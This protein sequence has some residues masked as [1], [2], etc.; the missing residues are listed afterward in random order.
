MPA[1]NDTVE[2]VLARLASGRA[3]GVVTRVELLDAGITR[4]EIE[5]RLRSGLL[6]R[7]YHGVYRVGHRAPSVEARYLAAVKACGEGAAISGR[8]AAHLL[9]LVKGSP[10]PPEVTAPRKR[11]VKGVRTRVCRS[12]DRTEVSMCRGVPT[13]TVPRTLVDIAGAI[14]VDAL[15]RACHEAGVRYRTTPR[16]VDAALARRPRI[17]GAGRLRSVLRG[18]RR[19]T[20]SG[21]ERRFL[22]VILPRGFPAPITNRVADA[23]RVDC[24]WP[25]HRLTVE[26]DS[27]RYHAS[28]LAWEQDREREREARRRGDEFRRFTYADVFEDTAYMLGELG[29]LLA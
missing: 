8:A 6:I 29:R 15:A 22:E 9:G 25:E 2:R 27:Y 23:H 4:N 10:P 7:E 1:K 16:Q 21:L 3:W 14:D 20:L 17:P 18:E 24:R 26:L 28:R 11:R 12:I 5:G 19:V 13:T